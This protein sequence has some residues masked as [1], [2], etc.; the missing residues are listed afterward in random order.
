MEEASLATASFWMYT[1]LVDEALYG[2]DSRGLMRRLA[3][4]GVQSR[5]LWQPLHLSPAH[6][7]CQSYLCETAEKLY[8]Q[9]LS[10]PSFVGMTEA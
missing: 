7:G 1:V 10:L 9:G 2:T 6:A 5:P 8:R 4:A 3:H